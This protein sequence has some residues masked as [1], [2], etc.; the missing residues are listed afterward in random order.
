VA[1]MAAEASARVLVD[2][3]AVHP[4]LAEGLQSLLMKL[5]RFAL[6]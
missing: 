4:T 5:D 6:R 2:A 1:L 3:E